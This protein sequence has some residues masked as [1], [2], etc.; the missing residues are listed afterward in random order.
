MSK[1]WIC[2]DDYEGT[3]FHLGDTRTPEG[4]KEWALSMNEISE[5][6]DYDRFAKLP[7]LEAMEYVAD[8]WQ[9]GIVP[10]DE[11]DE[12]HRQLRNRC[13]NNLW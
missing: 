5:S 1:E 6:D 13:E 4:W 9:I 12:E 7:P 8:M 10:Y 3:G 2:I 11:D